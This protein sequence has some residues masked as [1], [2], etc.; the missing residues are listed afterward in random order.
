MVD[1][2]FL[3]YVHLVFVTKYRK[4]V[5][6]KDVD[7]LREIFKSIC[8]DFDATLVEMNGEDNRSFA[9]R[10][11]SQGFSFNLVNSLKGFQVDFYASKGRILKKVL[12]KCFM[13]C[14]LFCR[15]MR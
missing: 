1:T 15:I 14:E 7:Q 5:F 13:E 8:T 12:E 10:I 3:A 11:S 9:D 2:A 4:H 6:D